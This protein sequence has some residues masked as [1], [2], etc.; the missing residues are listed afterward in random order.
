MHGGADVKKRRFRNQLRPGAGGGGRYGV[1]RASMA[2]K[3]SAGHRDALQRVC[4]PAF[5]WGFGLVSG[6]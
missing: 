2:G 1:S 4:P 6:F 5:C 3:R